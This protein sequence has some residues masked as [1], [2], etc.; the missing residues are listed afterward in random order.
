MHTSS[1]FR[2]F[3]IWLTGLSGSG[4]TTVAGKLQQLLKDN[5][6]NS[7]VL[8]GDCLRQGICSDLGFGELDR[9]ENIRRA[10]YISR[11]L[12]DSGV[13]VISAF[14]S[15]FASDRLLVKQLF[16]SGEMLEVYCNAPLSI[17]EQRD[18]K[19]LYKKARNGVVSNFTGI[20]SNYEPPEDPDI[21]VDTVYMSPDQ[22]AQLIMDILVD[23]R[24]IR[25]ENKY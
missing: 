12:V 14:I 21:E 22:S 24:M 1:E 2:P 8:D 10:G 17:C 23:L 6:Y 18:V 19:G 4:K 25:S 9:K 11:I 7:F 16:Q 13:I 3:L 5:N 15:P 20:T